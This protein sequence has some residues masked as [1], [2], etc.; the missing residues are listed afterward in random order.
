MKIRRIRS[1]LTE[2]R[3][4]AESCSWLAPR[5]IEFRDLRQIINRLAAVLTMSGIV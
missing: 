5:Q 2:F 1:K 3:S 4:S